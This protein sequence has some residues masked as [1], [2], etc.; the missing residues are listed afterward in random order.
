MSAPPWIIISILILVIITVL[1]AIFI[2][3]YKKKPHNPDYY[4]FFI[5]GI[6]WIPLGLVFKNPGFWIG[7]LVFMAVG[8]ANK[9]KWKTNHRTLKD[10]DSKERKTI[11]IVMIILGLSVLAGLVAFYIAQ[12]I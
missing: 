2:I 6:T 9:D 1:L 5:I 3:R 11:I 8:L 7:G 12:N 4:T 10:M